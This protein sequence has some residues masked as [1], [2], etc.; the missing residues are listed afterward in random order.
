MTVKAIKQ[1][2]LMKSW[3]STNRFVL[4]RDEMRSKTTTLEHRRMPNSRRS[5]TL[6]KI[7]VVKGPSSRHNSNSMGRG[8]G[9]PC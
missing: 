1:T 6:R 5:S 2:S 9:C 8:R 4:L 3:S 7:S